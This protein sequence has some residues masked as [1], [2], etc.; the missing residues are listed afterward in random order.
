MPPSGQTTVRILAQLE[1]LRRGDLTAR[2]ELIAQ[3]HH[4]LR[5]IAGRMFSCFSRLHPW[6]EADDVL[7]TALIRL[8]KSLA[9][10]TPITM[11]EYMGLASLQ[12][13]RTLIDLSRRYFGPDGLASRQ[14]HTPGGS[15]SRSWMEAALVRS[16]EP[17]SLED[18]TEFHECVAALPDEL[19]E[20]FDLL[21]YQGLTQTEA[22]EVLEVSERT[23]RRQWFEA[24]YR[25]Q[26]IISERQA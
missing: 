12:I 9:D 10:I 5:L 8:H 4:R 19:R 11:R 24:R 2:D 14:A 25:L 16:G 17:E 7:Q 3:S 1:R 15:P 26:L 23:V 21:W 18:W 22:A 6:E 20:M 13:R